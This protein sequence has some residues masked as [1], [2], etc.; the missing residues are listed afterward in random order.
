MANEPCPR[1][2]K[3]ENL[4]SHQFFNW[5]SCVE[6]RGESVVGKNIR[7]NFAKNMVGRQ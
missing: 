5:F 6:N 7:T 4:L 1:L 3:T 2:K